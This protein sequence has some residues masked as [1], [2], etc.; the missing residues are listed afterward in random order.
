M[1]IDEQVV[2]IIQLQD[3]LRSE[4]Q[5]LIQQFQQQGYYCVMLTGDRQVTAEC[6]AQQLGVDQVIA[7]V[8][9][10]QKAEQILKLQKQGRKVAMI[11]DGIND[12]PALAQANVG[13]AMYN[14]SEIAIE[15]ADLSLMRTGLH[16]LADIL[17][18]SKRV[19]RNMQQSLIGAF[20]Y[21]VISIPVAAGVFYSLTGWLLNPMLSAIAMT[22]SSITV[23]LNSQRLL[24]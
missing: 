8:L 16:P 9:P 21:N 5:Q 14:G 1:A 3:R 18:F 4:S 12:S 7:E 24:K 19:M 20:I 22:L 17:P 6:Y 11:G 10:E 15:T 2:G 23:V 13:I